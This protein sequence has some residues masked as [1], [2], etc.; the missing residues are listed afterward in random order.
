MLAFTAFNILTL[1][2]LMN[3]PSSSSSPSRS[4]SN[5][6]STPSGR[7]VKVKC[8]FCGNTFYAVP[9]DAVCRKCNRPANRPL[10]PALWVAAFLVPVFGLIYS[11]W[12]RPHSPFA[13][14]QGF[15]MSFLGILLYAAAYGAKKL[16]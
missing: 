9:R 16:L 2:S 6:S 8:S 4:S 11:A 3:P 14:R 15:L 7:L 10:P 5:Q 1:T 13:A 12:L